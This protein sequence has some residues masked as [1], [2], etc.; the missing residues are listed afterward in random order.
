MIRRGR[1]VLGTRGEEFHTSSRDHQARLHSDQIVLAMTR[2]E[3]G[4]CEHRTNSRA[5]SSDESWKT[6]LG[7]LET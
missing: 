3:A 6:T 1:L 7:S 4:P 2:W 5:S